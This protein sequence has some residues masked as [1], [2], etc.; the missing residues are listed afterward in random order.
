MKHFE[1]FY[2]ATAIK[3]SPFTRSLS[4]SLFLPLSLSLSS[5]VPHNSYI[6]YIFRQT[7]GQN[8]NVN[9]YLL[10]ARATRTPALTTQK[11]LINVRMRELYHNMPAN[12]V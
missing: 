11:M 6:L 7:Q 5:M 3:T 2:H 1:P 4:H 12:P 10:S 9:K 8:G